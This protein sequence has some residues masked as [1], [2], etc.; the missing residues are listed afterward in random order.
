MDFTWPLQAWA[1]TEPFKQPD[2][3]GFLEE[4]LTTDNVKHF[5][6][7]YANYQG[8][9]AVLHVPTFDFLQ[10]YE[11]LILTLCC[12]GAVY[13]DRIKAAQVRKLISF[14][15]DAI[16]RNSRI[17]K[18]LQDEDEGQEQ[19][20]EGLATTDIEELQACH[21]LHHLAVYHGD[22]VLREQ[23]RSDTILA[24]RLI[25][26][27]G[28]LTPAGPEDATCYSP[29]HDGPLHGL[30]DASIWDWRAWVEQERRL[31]MVY[32]W[33]LSDAALVAYWNCKPQFNPQ[34]IKLPL[35][36][37]DAAWEAKNAQQCANALGLNGR[38][39]QATVNRTGSRRVKQIEMHH[40]V[41][42]LQSPAIEFISRS[43]NAH[44]KFILIHALHVQLWLV[45]RQLSLESVNTPGSEPDNIAPSETFNTLSESE[46]EAANNE[47]ST[48]QLTSIPY[49]SLSSLPSDALDTNTMLKY[50]IQALTKW[51]RMWDDDMAVQYPDAGPYRP[52]GFWRD[53]VHFYWLAHSLLLANRIHDWKVSP[54]VRFM[55]VMMILKKARAS[56][57]SDASER[58]E[59]LGAVGNMD[60]GYAL[61]GLT[62]DMRRLFRPLNQQFEN[63]PSPPDP[64]V[65]TLESTPA[66]S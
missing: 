35:P 6:E 14:T 42:A 54:D 17:R 58:G 36:C 37:D 55:H 8:H 16:S 7:L 56:A 66:S 10:A 12:V 29:L 52:F 49:A 33:Y 31:R 50:T 41:S 47:F 60:E 46:W 65:S 44:S 30:I 51:K 39:I 24:A 43:T 45:Q 4:C 1:V 9:W 27:L 15:R 23:A 25:R 53:G 61:E 59:S 19:G 2:N 40:A 48:K 62:L 34:D 32:L 5:I 11:G 21:M 3:D 64:Q 57:Q 20:R 13:S 63:E 38:D 26:R 22:P 18:L 28:L